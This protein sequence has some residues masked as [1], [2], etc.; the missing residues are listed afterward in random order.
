MRAPI[1]APNQP[2]NAFESVV[3]EFRITGIFADFGN[4]SD[5]VTQNDG[6]R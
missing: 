5:E 4:D 3:I 1:V 6:R 2:G